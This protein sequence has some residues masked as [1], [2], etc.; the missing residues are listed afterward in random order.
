MFGYATIHVRSFCDDSLAT[1]Q[2]LIHHRATRK[3]NSPTGR[4]SCWRTIRNRSLASLC[5][6][7]SLQVSPKCHSHTSLLSKI[8]AAAAINPRLYEC[9]ASWLREIPAKDVVTS[10]L[11]DKILAAIND[12]AS[13]ES[14][15]ECLCT[16]YRDTREVDESQEVIQI[17]YPRIVALRPK[18]L[19]AAETE[20]SDLMKGV[21]RIFAEAG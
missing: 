14:A 12:E 17:L 19:E 4:G 11:L 7:R 18:I 16:I 2:S 15:V 9:I 10:P 5:R 13:F 21:T 6:T 8:L 3:R 20:D 1:D